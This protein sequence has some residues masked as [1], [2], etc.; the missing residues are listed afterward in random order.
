MNRD[1]QAILLHDNPWLRDTRRLG[2]WLE[3][4]LPPVYIPRRAGREADGTWSATGRAHLVVGPRQAGKSTLIWAYLARRGS[5]VLFI[6]CEQGPVQ[7]WCRSAPLFL[8]GL[9]QLVTGPVA[10]FF[11][12]A[13]HLDNAG[14]FLK[15][16]VDRRFPAPILATG[17]S[18]FHLGARVRE[19]LAGRATRTRLLPFSLDEVCQDLSGRPPALRE[20]EL[21]QRFQRHLRFG[22]YPEAW[23]AR[24]PEDTLTGLV[25]AVVLR[26]A[27]DLHRIARP[28][29]FRRLLR[30]AAIQA[31]NLVNLSEWA[32]VAG[33]GRDT[34]ASYLEV[35]ENAHILVRLRPFV[36]GKRS[37]LTRAEKVFFV[38]QGI[39]HHLLHDFRTLEERADAGSVLESWVATEIWKILPPGAGLHFW[40]STSKAEVDFVLDLPQALIG[41]EVKAGGSGRQTLPRAARSFIGAYQPSLFLMVAPHASG[42]LALGDT[43]IRWISPWQLTATLAPL[44]EA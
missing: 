11:E 44:L 38:D 21:L 39:R 29:A 37:E 24:R 6:D 42:R 28:D 36:G 13:Q 4:H 35:L 15:G 18:S 33:V 9:D 31:G 34:V 7:E 5:P 20:A 10:L 30:L 17:S 16:L 14:L 2:T 43:E 32:S 23:L 19:S 12:E 8:S 22:G 3:G 41:L 25:E 26:D 1:V 40:R 27:S